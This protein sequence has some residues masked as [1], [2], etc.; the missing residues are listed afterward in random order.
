MYYCSILSDAS[1]QHLHLMTHQCQCFMGGDCQE[2]ESCF[3]KSFSNSSCYCLQPRPASV[4]YFNFLPWRS[5]VGFFLL[6]KGIRVK[7]TGGG[8]ALN[9]FKGFGEKQ[10]SWQNC[11]LSCLYLVN[12][13]SFSFFFF[14]LEDEAEVGG[15]SELLPV[16]S[17]GVDVDFLKADQAGEV[18]GRLRAREQ[19]IFFFKRQQQMHHIHMFNHSWGALLFTGNNTLKLPESWDQQRSAADLTSVSQVFCSSF[20]LTPFLTFPLLFLYI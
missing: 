18:T 11:G 19:R 20:I 13:S 10:T 9:S 3:S 2:G 14:Y 7:Q 15:S 17:G 6:F 5:S 8:G 12:L 4:I 1:F 16:V